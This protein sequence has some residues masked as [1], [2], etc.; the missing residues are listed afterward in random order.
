M[1]KSPI[2]KF[3]T[4]L[5]YFLLAV[6]IIAV[7]R[8]SGELELFFDFFRQAWGV[9]APFFYGFLLAYIFNIPSSNIQKL[10]VKT[11]NTFIVKRKKVI[12]LLIVLLLFVLLIVLVLNIV[13]PAVANSVAFFVANLPTYWGGVMGLIN[14]FNNLDLFGLHINAE[15]IIAQVSGL[16]ENFSIDTI[17]G[18]INAIMGAATAVFS[19]AIAFI[20]SIY[21]LIEKDNC[22]AYLNKLLRVFATD[23]VRIT[24]I[25]IFSKL[26][27]NFRQYIHTQTID[28]MILGT[29]A[30][31]A[32]FFMRS[33]FALVLGLML[34][35]V[36]YIPYF[37]S[38]F[39]TL[40]AVLVVTFT[41]GLTMGLIAAVVLF[42]LQQIDA[43]IIQP[44]L[45]SGSFALSPLLVIISI[46]IGG[47]IAGIFGM[48]IAIPIVAVLKDLLDD[49]V[50]YVAR[51]K[52][53]ASDELE[54]QVELNF[55]EADQE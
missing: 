38:I 1:T 44:K 21:I 13:I 46:T 24:I 8:I 39:G 47:A 40:V 55:Q 29:M 36:N 32:L 17:W 35:I 53:D 14:D 52:S 27:K 43:N 30:T 19:G 25:D 15:S 31:A 54:G 48:I 33:P 20:S 5:P 23:R 11:N 37:G 10:L 51:K 9:V 50:A 42:I 26:N 16:F 34:G 22:K 18:P 6:A 41:Q 7:Y 4:L 49:V 45:M 12:S 3:K 2:D 28:G